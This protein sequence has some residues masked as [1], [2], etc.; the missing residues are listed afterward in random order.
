LSAETVHT[1]I[2]A[3]AP[4]SSSADNLVESADNLAILSSIEI[5]WCLG[6]NCMDVGTHH[7]IVESAIQVQVRFLHDNYYQ[8]ILP[9][10]I[11]KLRIIDHGSSNNN[12]NY[13]AQQQQQPLTN[14][15]TSPLLSSKEAKSAINKRAQVP[16]QALAN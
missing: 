13:A 10:V 8:K 4:L 15:G 2:I 14:V 1:C 11:N 7:I 6:K 16:L 12:N 5:I 9:K 3:I